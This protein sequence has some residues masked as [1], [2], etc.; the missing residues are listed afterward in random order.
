MP[1]QLIPGKSLNLVLESSNDAEAAAELA[2]VVP[3]A[4]FRFKWPV[5]V[6]AVP[7]EDIAFAATPDNPPADA[8]VSDEEL[9]TPEHDAKRSKAHKRKPEKRRSGTKKIKKECGTAD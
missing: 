3:P 2:T 7:S 9:W 4:A 1:P 6:S 5:T 8:S